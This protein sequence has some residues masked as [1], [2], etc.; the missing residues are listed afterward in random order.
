MK[1]LIAL[2]AILLSS[3]AFA[4]ALSVDDYLDQVEGKSPGYRNSSINAEAY[5]LL[6]SSANIPTAPYLFAGYTNSDDRQ[7]TVSPAAQGTRTSGFL[8]TIGLGIQSPI[9]LNAKYSFN[10]THANI[11]GAS[12]TLLPVP[13]Y[14]TS[15]NKLELSQSLLRNGFGSE[16]RATSDL[17]RW[18]NE[19]RSL[20]EQ[21]RR[22]GLIAEAEQTYWRLA[23][24][25]RTVNVQKDVLS[26]SDRLLKWAK[27]RAGLQLS[28]RADFLQAQANNELSR[29]ELRRALE[30]EK[31]AARAFNLL[32]YKDGD[33]VSESLSLMSAEELL[34][35]S[36]PQRT[37]T[38]L[39]VQAAEAQAKAS[40]AEA[41]VQK[42]HLKPVVDVFANLAWTGRDAQRKLAVEEAQKS[43]RRT[44]SFG[45]TLNVPLAIGS[46]TKGLKGTNM[47]QDAAAFELEQKRIAENMDW[48]DLSSRLADARERVQLLQKIEEIQRDKY[49]HEQERLLRGR[50]TTYQAVT[51]EQDYAQAQLL[52]L[53]TRAE[54]LQIL[55]QLK[56]FRGN[57]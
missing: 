20:G 34:A 37:A 19:A 23:L 22:Q 31:S 49:E 40:V 25:R 57:E 28:D 29:L 36:T 35:L 32:R 16:I 17:Q 24:A 50:T 44:T 13:D 33:R 8:Y 46:L 3:A 26:R 15:Y 43:G 53:R 7:E 5:S 6:R 56:L 45:V 52:S 4:Q 42:E 30:E 47:L 21:F 14:F 55:S 11:M 18:S 12:P 54:L 39:D 27:R 10:T 48:Q 41:Q 1:H 51:F 38:R 2:A 9:G